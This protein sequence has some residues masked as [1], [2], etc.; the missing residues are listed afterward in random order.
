MIGDGD[1]F[2]FNPAF[3]HKLRKFK[4]PPPT[5]ARAATEVGNNEMDALRKVQVDA[6]IVRVMKSRRTLSYNDLLDEVVRQLSRLFIP[7]PALVKGRIEDLIGRGYLKRNDD[8]RN[9]FDYIA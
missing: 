1:V 9:L 4:L 7:Q 5:A 6:C 2:M 3:A 8:N